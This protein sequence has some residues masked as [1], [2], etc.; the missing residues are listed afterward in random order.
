VARLE[1][2]TDASAWYAADYAD[3]ASYAYYLTEKDIAELDQAVALVETRGLDIKVALLT[4]LRH[5]V[6]SP[7]NFDSS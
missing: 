2:V 1:P 3:P 4:P 6:F 7:S 5:F